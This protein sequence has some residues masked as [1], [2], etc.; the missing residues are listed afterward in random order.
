MNES[1][2]PLALAERIQKKTGIN[3]E[4]AKRFSYDFFAIVSRCLKQEDSF[5]IH[6]F[7]TFKKLWVEESTGRNP[8]TNNEITIP[9]HW[10]IKFTPSKSVAERI[11]K[12]Y[13]HLKA[14]LIHEKSFKALQEKS[15]FFQTTQMIHSDSVKDEELN[16]DPDDL[17]DDADDEKKTSR[18]PLILIPAAIVL[19]ALLL[20]IFKMCSAKPKTKQIAPPEEPPVTK[21]Q[22]D[23]QKSVLSEYRVPAGSCYYKIAEDQFDNRHVWPIIYAENSQS[24]PDPDL[25]CAYSNIFI[26]S[27]DTITSDAQNAKSAY[28][29]TYNSY[30]SLIKT[31]PQNARNPI[32]QFRAVRVLVSGD[33]VFPG[34]IE[35]YKNMVSEQDYKDA[36]AIRSNYIP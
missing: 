1:I 3:A 33:I 30:Y 28:I 6:R 26:P 12:K 11:N 29:K 27:K 36:V 24:N 19:L 16:S 22:P 4:L 18:L 21:E 32:R 13:A 14:Q 9:A 25:I 23:T 10:R 20:L 15:D 7:G 5:I 34:F 8:Q 17:I 35:E 2:T 31:Q